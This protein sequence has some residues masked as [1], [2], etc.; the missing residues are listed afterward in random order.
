MKLTKFEQEFQ[1]TRIEVNHQHYRYDCDNEDNVVSITCLYCNTTS[2]DERDIK[3]QYCQRCNKH[4][5]TL[6]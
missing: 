5:Y 4:H 6:T 3:E 1:K 2:V